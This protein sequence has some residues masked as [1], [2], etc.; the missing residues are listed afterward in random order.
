MEFLLENYVWIIVVAVFIIMMIIGY[1]ADKKE[2][3]LREPMLKDHVDEMD[4]NHIEPVDIDANISE[5]EDKPV[6]KDEDIVETETKDD[7]YDWE[8]NIDNPI[9]EVDS[10]NLDNIENKKDNDI[11]DS[12]IPEYDDS[13][14][15][16]W[17][18]T[19][20]NLVEKNKIENNESKDSKNEMEELEDSKD[21]VKQSEEKK[22]SKNDK[23]SK[24][25]KA[26][27]KLKNKDTE[28][29]KEEKPIKEE[30][31]KIEKK[32]EKQ[33]DEIEKSEIEEPSLQNDSWNNSDSK[34]DDMEIS[35][36]NIDTLNDEIKDVI[37]NDDI[38]KF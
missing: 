14:D 7:F 15:T 9:N 22:E 28:E 29:E 37:D 6:K 21:E 18:E 36:P 1:F 5:W 35:L 13:I 12:A 20:D 3:K 23:K 17:G 34:V 11:E 26:T 24:K 16:N 10:N 31:E 2:K 27:K 8:N 19:F 32:E 38:W 25:K 33:I 30:P 4:D